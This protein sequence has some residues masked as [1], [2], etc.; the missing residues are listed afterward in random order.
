MYEAKQ[1]PANNLPSIQLIVYEASGRAHI[2]GRA[3]IQGVSIKGLL[4]KNSATVA[5]ELPNSAHVQ[6]DGSERR[7]ALQLQEGR[8][9]SWKGGQQGEARAVPLGETPQSKHM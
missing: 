9:A 8:V 4:V 2:T 1:C 7:W 5:T 3:H 6:M